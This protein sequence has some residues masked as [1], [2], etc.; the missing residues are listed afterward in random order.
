MRECGT[1]VL[2][3]PV[4]G[5]HMRRDRTMVS[6]RR[7]A[8]PLAALY[9]C[10]LLA[11]FLVAIGRRSRNAEV[12]IEPTGMGRPELTAQ[13]AKTALVEMLR[14]LAV[15]DPRRCREVWGSTA[16][17]RQLA[18]VP[19][20][21]NLDGTGQ[22]GIFTVRRDE[23]NYYFWGGLDRYEGSFEW[24]KGAWRASDYRMTAHGCIIGRG[25]RK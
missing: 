19:I 11:L 22:I 9:T 12:A 7:L 6:V 20:L 14:R 15:R 5:L 10:M 2:R 25:S 4:D 3:V 1:G 13:D 18:S 23:Q 21:T 8:G 16:P 17:D 24:E